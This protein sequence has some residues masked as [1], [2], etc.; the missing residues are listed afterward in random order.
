MRSSAGLIKRF[1]SNA[2]SKKTQKVPP[3]QNLT[4]EFFE[5]IQH[6]VYGDSRKIDKVVVNV[7]LDAETQKPVLVNRNVSTPFHCLTHI[8]KQ[9]AENAVLV[10]VEPSVGEN[11]ICCVH[12]PIEDQARITK[13]DFQTTSYTDILNAAYWRSC[14][15]ATG[16][17]LKESF[18]PELLVDFNVENNVEDGFFSVNV[19]DL[20]NISYDELTT[21]NSFGKKFLKEGHPFECI[22]VPT[23]IA[24]E[25]SLDCKLLVRLGRHV[26]AASGPVIQSTAQIGQYKLVQAKPRNNSVQV[27]GVSLP[28]AQPTTSYS[29]GLIVK[30]ASNMCRK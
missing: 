6:Q 1:L 22:N 25:N 9:V 14:G 28:F 30:N 11:Y 15:I 26:F 18:Y 21:I 2:I 8:S 12:Q 7:T 16:A 19:S 4:S 20:Q 24:E 29:W 13:I 5:H 10:E 17:I 3:T 27:S 23:H